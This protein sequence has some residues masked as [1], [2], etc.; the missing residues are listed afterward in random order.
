TP[1]EAY[2]ARQK[3]LE[4]PTQ[5]IPNRRKSSSTGYKGVYL[6]SDG[7]KYYGQISKEGVRYSTTCYETPEEANEA[8]LKFLA[9]L[10]QETPSDVQ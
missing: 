5:E 6:H 3:F 4:D 2:E 1:E 9:S 8:R 10:D 7:K